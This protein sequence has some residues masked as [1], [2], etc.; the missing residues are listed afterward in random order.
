L[1]VEQNDTKLITFHLTNSFDGSFNA[2]HAEVII[3]KNI[4]HEIQK[5]WVIVY[6][7]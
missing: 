1:E 5:P 6:Y 2:G 3:P 4:P 7:E